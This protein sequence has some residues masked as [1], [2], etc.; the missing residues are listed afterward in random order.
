MKAIPLSFLLCLASLWTAGCSADGESRSISVSAQGY[1]EAVPDT[2][3]LNLTV[4]HTAA[5]LAQAS[6]EVDRVVAL[7]TETARKGGVKED[8]IDSSRLTA[9]PEYKW[10][11]QERQYLGETV[12]RNVTLKITDLDSYGSLLGQL[13]QFNLHGI[14]QP[15]VSHSNL[16]ALQLQALQNAVDR[17]KI[18]AAAIARQVD[19]SLGQ[20]ISVEE[21]GSVRPEP[22]MMMAM[23]E[24]VRSADSGGSPV[25]SFAKTRI[26]A[27]V[28]MTF[29]LH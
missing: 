8:A 18:K 14:S 15:Q 6:G 22:R 5:T 10:S 29:T 21:S 19:G 28:S 17:G 27:S 9:F 11:K 1:V 25:F 3:T 24:S 2:L 26:S 23:A 7:V 13:S 12:Q 20:V 4:R 16:E